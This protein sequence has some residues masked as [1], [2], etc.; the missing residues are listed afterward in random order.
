MI[1]VETARAES[2]QG[3]SGGL[4]KERLVTT[5]A[6]NAGSRIASCGKKR[7]GGHQQSVGVS[8]RE[9]AL[10]V[11]YEGRFNEKIDGKVI[12][13]RRQR[14]RGSGWSEVKVIS[15]DGVAG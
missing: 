7:V 1:R 9:L 5:K 4:S 8:I 15:R 6:K 11:E 3:A 10:S 2:L 12:Q 13:K 14:R